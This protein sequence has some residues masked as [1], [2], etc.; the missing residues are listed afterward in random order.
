MY[1]VFSV[2]GF[3]T[4]ALAEWVVRAIGGGVWRAVAGIEVAPRKVTRRHNKKDIKRRTKIKP[5]IKSVNYTH[6]LPTR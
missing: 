3:G 1:V 4:H 6:I 5:F 2:G